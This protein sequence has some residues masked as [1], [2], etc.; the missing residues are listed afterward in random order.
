MR[1]N[2][3]RNAS[4][5]GAQRVLKRDF[6]SRWSQEFE[7]EI[8]DVFAL[9]REIA[10]AV[11]RQLQARASKGIYGGARCM[12]TNQQA[13]DMFLQANVEPRGA[14]LGWTEAEEAR[15]K[16]PEQ[17]LRLDPNLVS[18]ASQLSGVYLDLDLHDSEAGTRARAAARVFVIGLR[19]GEPGRRRDGVFA[20]PCVC[21]SAYSALCR[22]KGPPRPPAKK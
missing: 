4:A 22:V 10:D 21:G 12:T 18:A 14:D 6:A 9:Q 15:I 2:A 3:R 16:L 20:S 13:Y 17:A 11:A 19:S 1:P 5:A 8:A 7:R